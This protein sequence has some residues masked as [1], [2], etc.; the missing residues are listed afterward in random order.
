MTNYKNGK[1]YKLVCYDPTLIYIGSTCQSNLRCRL[2]NHYQN[3]KRCNTTTIRELYEVG[4]VNISLLELYPCNTK[5]ELLNRKQYYIDSIECVN[6]YKRKQIPK[7]YED[8]PIGKK[9]QYDRNRYLDNR[10]KFINRAKNY[11]K[12]N[13]KK[14]NNLNLYQ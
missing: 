12:E 3:Y 11:Y 13:T 5:E 14:K 10:E 4:G 8:T 6:K 7:I 2:S 1:I 9:K